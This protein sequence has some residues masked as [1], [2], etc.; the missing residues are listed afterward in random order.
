MPVELCLGDVDG[1]VEVIVG[2]GGVE[3]LVFR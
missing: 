1:G 2:Q 3:D